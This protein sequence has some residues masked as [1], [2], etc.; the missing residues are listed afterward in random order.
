MAMLG[1]LGE[2]RYIG[3]WGPDGLCFCGRAHV[4][5]SFPP[6]D[7]PIYMAT[8]PEST[9][10]PEQPE[11][12]EPTTRSRDFRQ[13]RSQTCD[14]S[15]ESPALCAARRYDIHRCV[16]CKITTRFLPTMWLQRARRSR[17]G[18]PFPL[19]WPPVG[20]CLCGVSG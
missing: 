17:P 13:I 8:K 16:G 7:N 20:L 11:P 9:D 1:K 2:K 4:P 5:A 14:T 6:G 12:S 10:V 3:K 15:Q 18:P 19:L